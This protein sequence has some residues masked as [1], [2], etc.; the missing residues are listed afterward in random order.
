MK[1]KNI[2]LLGL[3]LI[4]IVPA[5][6]A[7]SIEIEM[8]DSFSTGDE[9]SFDYTITSEASQQIEYIASV[10]CPNAPLALL[11]IKTATL[12]AKVP[13]TETYSYLI[14][15]EDIE[16]QTCE[17]IVSIL[18]PEEISEEKSFEIVTDPSFEFN[19]L[20]CKDSSCAEQAK[21]FIRNKNI[22]LD[23]TSDV[24]DVNVVITLTNPNGQTKQ[25]TL[26]TTIKAEQIGTYEL[27]VTASKE[28]YKTITKS[29][30][31]GVIKSEASIKSGFYE[32][33]FFKENKY[34]IYLIIGVAV[35][36]LIMLIVYFKRRKRKKKILIGSE[37]FLVENN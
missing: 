22:Y 23:Y 19:I 5:L 14:V 3:I 4:M 25:L 1:I 10:D 13:F 17:A 26:P 31:F 27:E 20:T 18:I 28:G 11:E 21:V 15:N 7:I 36:V 34:L 9:I 30:Q 6:S 16:S 29:L 35:I 8:E 24:F 2:I 33:G 32:E 37:N 12:Q